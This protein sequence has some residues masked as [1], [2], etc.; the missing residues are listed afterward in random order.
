M[1]K[2]KTAKQKK[3]GLVL[4]NEE[5]RFVHKGDGYTIIYRRIEPTRRHVMVERHTVQG[6]TKLSLA[7]NAILE[8]CIC[9]WT[10]VEDV[11]GQ[12]V[13]YDPSLVQQIPD[14]VQAVILDLVQKNIS[15]EDRE[16]G[17]SGTTSGSNT[18]TTDSPVIDAGPKT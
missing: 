8:Y 3:R 12:P 2:A 17:N 7:H 10:G 5:E 14:E 16:L 13:P 18:E 1:A 9:G 4:V 15:K 6:N 11:N